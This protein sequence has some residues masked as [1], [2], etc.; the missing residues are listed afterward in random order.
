MFMDILSSS[1]KVCI[2]DKEA[3][4]VAI[5]IKVKASD[6]IMDLKNKVMLVNNLR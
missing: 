1:L 6:T 2:E 5:T 3:S 4:G